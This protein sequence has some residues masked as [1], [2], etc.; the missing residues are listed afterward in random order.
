MDI[1]FK[2]KAGLNLSDLNL[3]DKTFDPSVASYLPG[4][5]CV[6]SV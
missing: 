4:L 6:L 1:S 5:V 3:V 2:K